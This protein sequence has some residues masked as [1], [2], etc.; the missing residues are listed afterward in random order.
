[1]KYTF[2]AE[3]EDHPYS[4]YSAR[5]HTLEF[6]AEDLSTILSSFEDFLKGNGFSI[7]GCLDIVQDESDNWG[8]DEDNIHISLDTDNFTF[9]GAAAQPTMDFSHLDDGITI[10]NFDVKEEDTNTIHI[11]PFANITS[12]STFDTEKKCPV[13]RLS[14]KQMEGMHCFDTKCG[15]GKN[16]SESYYT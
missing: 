15:L 1:M 9:P 10:T 7:E 13:C 2:I 3:E 11:G 14:V 4:G 16:K 8:K 5:K 12:S 6:V